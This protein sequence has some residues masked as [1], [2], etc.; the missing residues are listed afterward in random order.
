MRL[1]PPVAFALLIASSV[2][3]WHVSAAPAGGKVLV[4]RTPN[5]GL[6]PEI[7]VDSS[8]TVHL[9]YLDGEP[10]AADVFYAR[11]FDGGRRFSPAIRVNSEPGSAIATGSI[12][13]AQIAI[14]RNGRV[15]VAWNG[16][17]RA[18]PG[19]SESHGA[20]GSPMLYA[21][22][23]PDGTAFEPQRNLMTRTMNLDG[24]GSVAADGDGRV[25]VAWHAHPAGD[26]AP[27]EET[28][29]LWMARSGD[30]GATFSAESLIESVPAGVC[31]C[32]AVRL[33]AAPDGRLALMYRSVV[34]RTRRD[35]QALVSADRGGT[36]R[37]TRLDEWSV[38]ACPMTS[39]SMALGR[40][41]MGAWE[42]EGQVHV[43]ALDG[44]TPAAAPS[45]TAVDAPVRKHP[46]IAIDRNGT[47]LL[48]W[49]E[50]TA[51][52]RGGSIA[53]RAFTPDGTPAGAE[54][55][56]DGLPAW[57]FAAVI[58]QKDAGFVVLY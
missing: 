13:G 42:S 32:C 37:A 4:L 14:G 24:G 47:M 21:R 34:E 25:Y 38:G 57:S 17:A 46:R 58:A 23:N 45:E 11:S 28:R 52:G 5:G 40:T 6:Q 26:D 44:S 10:A 35:V 36:F 7:A 8:G 54:G 51:W 12:R 53:W 30:D 27:G 20:P 15:H 22:S 49:T 43:G 9:V 16:S 18:I 41:L 33:F 39:M 55:R 56:Q 29:R 19:G 31:A 50:G 3:A 48:A 2:I 1:V